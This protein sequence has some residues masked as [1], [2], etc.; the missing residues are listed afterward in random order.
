MLEKSQSQKERWGEQEKQT[1]EFMIS[2]EQ[3]KP[4]KFSRGMTGDDEYFVGK[5]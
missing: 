1:C 2:A 4:L 5:S 3:A